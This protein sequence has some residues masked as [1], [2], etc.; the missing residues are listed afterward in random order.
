MTKA[1]LLKRI[2]CIAVFVAIAPQPAFAQEDTILLGVE[3]SLG[4]D[5]STVLG[6]LRRLYT[7]ESI[8]SLDLDGLPPGNQDNYLVWD[9]ES[10]PHT[11]HGQ[12]IFDPNN[13]LDYGRER[14]AF[15]CG[16]GR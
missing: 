5:R 12:V 2:A 13:R 4:M 14:M 10:R 8:D 16:N 7:V 1:S 6:E 11:Y 3:L 15:N 9:R